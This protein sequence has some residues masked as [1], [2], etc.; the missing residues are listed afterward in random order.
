MNKFKFKLFLLCY[1]FLGQMFATAISQ[2]V[3]TTQQCPPQQAIQQCPV[4]PSCPVTTEQVQ[5]PQL[6]KQ[7]TEIV[8]DQKVYPISAIDPTI[9]TNTTASYYPGLR[10][11][12]QMTVYTPAYGIRTNT[13][14]FGTEA[15]VSGNIVTSLSGADS[16]IPQNGLVISGHGK[17]KQWM[18][19]NIIVGAKVYVN[20][21]TKTLT[22][23]ITSESFLY[24][25]REK[26]KEAKEMVNYYH[27]LS[28]MY[29]SKKPCAYIDKAEEY[30]HK[31]QKDPQNVQ[32]YSSLAIDA[33]NQAL[34]TSLPFKSDELKGIWVRPTETSPEAVIATLDKLK[35]AG[36]DNVFLETYFH[37]KTIFPSKVMENY[38]FTSQNEKFM[39]FDPLK[40]WITE[41]HKRNIKVNIWFETFY[42]G[43]TNPKDNPKSIL[44]VNPSWGNKT[45]RCFDSMS[46]VPSLSEHGGYFLDPANPD[47][48]QFLENLI[49]EIITE[50]NPDGINLDY[51]RYPQSI[52]SKFSGYDL[53]NWGYTDY[54]R[55]E[56]KNCYGKDPIDISYDDPMWKL[57]DK[58]RQ[59]KVTSF[60]L[61]IN[62]ITK[63]EDVALTAV[64]FP[65][66]QKAL[67]TKQQDW[68]TW[69]ALGYID[70]FTPLLLTCDAK[71]AKVMMQD[72]ISNKS[73]NTKL[74]AGLF[75]TFMNGSNEDLIRQIHESRKIGAKGV[76]LFDYNH[77][78][79][80]Y[81]NTL[82]ACAFDSSA[83]TTGQIQQIKTDKFKKKR[84]FWHRN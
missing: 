14:E 29:D 10:G 62:K 60:V 73:Q 69:S 47:V 84:K 24:S 25:A 79:E 37:G 16:I 76:I 56:F 27:D 49:T 33:A 54:A 58:Y 35:A 42:V 12:N 50:Y 18:N 7:S 5:A 43:N 81:T 3:T 26:I 53:S 17:A 77:L 64:I 39:G 55:T 44:A 52:A 70:G 36:I 20:K 82:M 8:F 59:D 41:A 83:D 31:A 51:I 34:A 28:Y 30:L 48:Q 22:V 1:I 71:T 57:W 15:I 46:A 65:D 21:D 9:L 67:E 40:I 32:K 13:N 63:P 72:V 75:I 78:S 6:P 45:K 74:Y 2:E 4:A 66:R 68:K 23:Y 80:K 19:E 11:A 38:Q 61:R